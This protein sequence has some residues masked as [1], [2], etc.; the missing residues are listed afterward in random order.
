MRESDLTDN[1]PQRL[2]KFW[3][4]QF[5]YRNSLMGVMAVTKCFENIECVD[6]FRFDLPL[7]WTHL[8]DT[9]STSSKIAYNQISL[10]DEDVEKDFENKTELIE[11]K[12]GRG[13][14]LYSEEEFEELNRR[15]DDIKLPE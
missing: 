13:G 8:L 7:R 4:C 12:I 10:I 14:S 9:L 5:V 6:R 1:L 3:P 15:K 2:K 11:R